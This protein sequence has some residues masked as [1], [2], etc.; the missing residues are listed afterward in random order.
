MGT[1][2]TPTGPL[3]FI[4]PFYILFGLFLAGPA[5][6]AIVLSCTQ[7]DSVNPIQ[8]I[9]LRNYSRLLSDS[10]F[11]LAVRNTLWYMVSGLIVG[12]PL[13]LVLAVILNSDMVHGKRLLRTAY[14]MPI[15]TSTVVIAVMFTLIYDP[16]YGPISFVMQ[17]MGL[18][19]ID[20]L[21]DPSWSKVAIIGLLIW[22]WLGYNMV[23]FLAGLQSVPRELQEA[24]WID[25]ANRWQAFFHVTLPQL[26]PIIAFVAVVVLIGSAQV[27]D[28]PFILTK[29]GP[30][31]SSLS[32]VE[33]LYRVGFQFLQLGYASA[34]GVL[35][36]VVLF[37]LSLG[38][39]R[40]L[41][42][43]SED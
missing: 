24:A 17:S 19:T 8:W 32:L 6:F 23:Y 18:P 20:F 2:P 27:F 37:A 43:F 36:F 5:L 7:W 39:M 29:G 40:L 16:N 42:V 41:G 35:L 21:G 10:S 13:A 9:G 22:R 25:G 14:F 31:D 34:V 15:V 11:L 38:Q 1:A 3:P 30:A 28:E 12:C 4:S 26:R 33:Y